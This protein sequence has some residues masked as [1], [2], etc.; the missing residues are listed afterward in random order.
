[1]AASGK[2]G[3]RKSAKRAQRKGGPR[4]D[5]SDPDHNLRRIDN[6]ANATHCWQ[7]N[8]KR[9]G[10]TIS[11]NFSDGTY[12]SKAEAHAAALAYRDSVLEQVS[13]AGYTVWRRNRGQLRNSTGV[14]GVGR[15][16]RR[17]KTRGGVTRQPYW[18]AFWHDAD[19]IRHTASFAVAEFGEARAKALAIATRRKAMDECAAELLRRGQIYGA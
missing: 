6:T 13:G 4:K 16:A 11:K 12:G 10:R 18:Q 2:T 7:V 17:R 3:K 8:V 14:V 19:G 15:Y 5:P 9:R 1:M